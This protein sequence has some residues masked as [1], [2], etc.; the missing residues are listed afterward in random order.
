MVKAREFVDFRRHP[1]FSLGRIGGV[2]PSQ[3]SPGGGSGDA[4]PSHVVVDHHGSVHGT[5]LT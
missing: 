2:A 3:R 4:P 5:V 1:F